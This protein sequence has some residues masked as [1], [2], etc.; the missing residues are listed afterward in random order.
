M[1]ASHVTLSY[2][3]TTQ[4]LGFHNGPAMS[5]R[6]LLCGSDQHTETHGWDVPSKNL[7]EKVDL[8]CIG[9]FKNTMFVHVDLHNWKT[10]QE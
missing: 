7:K 6:S 8:I 1:I 3:N 4:P 2:S 9:D 10:C 5:D